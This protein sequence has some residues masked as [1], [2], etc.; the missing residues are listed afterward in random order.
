MT[1]TTA[2]TRR[3]QILNPLAT[4]ELLAFSREVCGIIRELSAAGR[5]APAAER[6]SC[7][8]QW[9]RHLETPVRTFFLGCLLTFDSWWFLQWKLFSLK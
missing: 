6:E 5:P 3:V 9:A 2:T 8:R 4:R 1:R 7:T